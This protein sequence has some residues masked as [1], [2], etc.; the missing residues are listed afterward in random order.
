MG[1]VSSIH[2]TIS[3]EPFGNTI[4]A[5]PAGDPS[6]GTITALPNGQAG[7]ISANSGELPKDSA[8]DELSGLISSLGTLSAQA[9][10]LPITLTAPTLPGLPQQT[11]QPQAT[12]YLQFG[13]DSNS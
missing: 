8:I 12:N 9:Q 3:A 11:Y 6:S 2:G 5:K 1:F 4:S 7:T 13:D 10:S